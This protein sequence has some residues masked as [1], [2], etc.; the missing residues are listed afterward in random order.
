MNRGGG[1]SRQAPE[2]NQARG[3]IHSAGLCCDP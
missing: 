2:K 3:A 1:R